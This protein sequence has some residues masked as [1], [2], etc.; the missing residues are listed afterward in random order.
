MTISA[1]RG[2]HP[3]VQRLER[4]IIAVPVDHQPRQLIAFAMNQ[5]IS[6]ALRHHPLPVC[7]R[8]SDAAQKERPDRCFPPGRKVAEEIFGRT[9]YSAPSLMPLRRGSTTTHGLACR[10]LAP[11]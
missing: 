9:R 3:L 11:I 4:E 6:I 8:G 2:V 1:S 10:S 7:L 5:S